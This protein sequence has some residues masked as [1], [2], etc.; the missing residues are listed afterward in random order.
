[1]SKDILFFSDMRV[2]PFTRHYY[3]HKRWKSVANFNMHFPVNI[4]KNCKIHTKI[5]G[6]KQRYS[7]T[8]SFLCLVA[9]ERTNPGLG[10]SGHC[11]P[12]GCQSL[13]DDSFS[14]ARQDLH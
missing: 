5:L 4:E 3:L 12:A 7:T 13:G 9:Q 2:H 10:E 1:M 11:F 6:F 8:W 14:Q